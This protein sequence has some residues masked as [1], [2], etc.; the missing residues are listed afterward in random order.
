VKGPKLILASFAERV[1]HSKE[2]EFMALDQV[3]RIF[4]FR[5]RTVSL[6]TKL[7][8]GQTLSQQNHHEVIHESKGRSWLAMTEHLWSGPLTLPRNFRGIP[9]DDYGDNIIMAGF[10]DAHIHFH[11]FACWQHRGRICWTGGAL[12]LPEEALF[13]F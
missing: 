7:I 11:S 8:R 2:D 10:I 12:H 9:T 13:G 6:M 5:S 1:N 4:R 3:C